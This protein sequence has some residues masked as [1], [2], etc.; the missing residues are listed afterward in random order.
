M[1]WTSIQLGSR[2][3]YAL[4]LALDSAGKL[5]CLITDTWLSSGAAALV[6]PF[7]PSLAARRHERLPDSKVRSNTAGRLL[8]DLRLRRQRKSS[9]STILERNE[10][11]GAWAA[12]Q[13]AHVGSP[14]LFSYSYTARLPFTAA[15]RRG[16][17]CILGQID[18]GPREEEVVAEQTAAYRHLAPPDEKAPT[19]Y[20]QLWREEIDLADK[21]IVNSPWSAKLLVE[22]GVPCEKLVEIP[23]VYAPEARSDEW[24]VTGDERGE[25]K[26]KSG[27]A[28]RL[29]ALF[30]G[31]VILRKGVGQLF[32]AIRMLKNEPVDF[33][34]AGPIGVRIPEEISRLPNVRFLGPVD[35]ATAEAL[36][37]ESD[38]FLFPTLS[39]G[40]G[41]TQLE[42]LGHGLPVIA[43][44]YCGQVVEN[45]VNGLVLS[46]VTA[47]ALAACLLDL[48]RDCDFLA[49]MKAASRLPS[50]CQPV[51][52]ETA[53]LSL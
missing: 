39:D 47:E 53:L 34:F 8:T 31:S 49:A 16:A 30:L 22:A 45:R 17:L 40:F 19:E 51:N 32:D 52:L 29:K 43:S 33:T 41:L 48:A 25:E 42:A 24:G 1:N 15:K 12:E 11:F 20:W 23:L 50:C 13:S 28:E 7:H 21:I 27:K 9:W 3:H 35:K 5:D 14:I 4:P 26:L 18:P 44:K 38:V 6:R 2:E 36:Y 37:R 10:W 46:E